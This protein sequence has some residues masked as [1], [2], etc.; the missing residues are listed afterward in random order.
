MVN[1]ICEILGIARRTYFHWQKN[2]EKAHA[3]NF[4]NN[5]FKQEELEE[6]LETQKIR[7]LELIK[8]FSAE[9]LENLLFN[10][11][12]NSE[13][14]LIDFVSYNLDLKIIKSKG[15][16]GVSPKSFLYF[17]QKINEEN[18]NL[19]LEDSKKFVLDKIQNDFY[20]PTI[21]G[22]FKAP[23]KHQQK[24]LYQLIQDKY[25]N[26]EVYVLVKKNINLK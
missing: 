24:S 20:N 23:T 22:I 26:V 4:F 2:E 7:K 19:K 25:S 17:F 13:D 3:I 10:K 21:F 11:N 14:Q 16:F 9:E 15:F 5:Y 8:G 6:F 1:T 12:N 18:P